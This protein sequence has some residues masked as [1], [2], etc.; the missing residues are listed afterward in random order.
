MW[1]GALG[2]EGFVAQV[3]FV[4]AVGEQ[5]V[6]AGDA[7][8]QVIRGHVHEVR[9][10]LEGVGAQDDALG[11]LFQDPV[12]V[13]VGV[14]GGQGHAGVFVEHGPDPAAV[15][16]EDARADG[17]RGVL[18]HAASAVQADVDAG[19]GRESALPVVVP[20]EFGGHQEQAPAL[21]EQCEAVSLGDADV[22]A[23]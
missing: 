16:L 12:G 21:A 14:A 9:E 3:V 2:G 20:L 13:P 23:P 11:G 19:G 10:S 6:E 5:G 18:V 15:V 7:R 4:G 17:V 1:V 8:G 22:V